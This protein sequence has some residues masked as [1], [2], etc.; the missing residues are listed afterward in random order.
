MSNRN[1]NPE[2]SLLT[3]CERGYFRCCKCGALFLEP[4]EDSTS[5]MCV[6]PTCHYP[7]PKHYPPAFT[8]EPANALPS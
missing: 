3:A 7:N 1:H 6:C 8:D 5:G 2:L 4:V